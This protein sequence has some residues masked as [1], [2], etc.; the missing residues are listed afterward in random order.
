MTGKQPRDEGAAQTKVIVGAVKRRRAVLG[1]S[2][3]RLAEEMTKAGVPWNADIVVNLEHG[4]RRSLRVHELMALAWV[5]DV[6]SPLDLL[7]PPDVIF[8]PVT[9]GGNVR[10]EAVR[11]WWLGETGPL[12]ETLARPGVRI[13]LSA[14]AE[15]FSDLP[16][17]VQQELV[18]LILSLDPVPKRDTPPADAV[19]AEQ[20]IRDLRATFPRLFAMLE[21]GDGD[22]Q[23]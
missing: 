9:P 18:Q 23:D 12:R 1:W 3:D 6:D 22:G 4:R 17:S 13:D 15:R 19:S 2:A 20:D 11:A 7:A 5:L 16:E 10:V 14:L 8:Y 21:A